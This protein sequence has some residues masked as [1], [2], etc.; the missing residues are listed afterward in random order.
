MQTYLVHGITKRCS[1]LHSKSVIRFQRLKPASEVC[2]ANNG[3]CKLCRLM[4]FMGILYTELRKKQQE[5]ARNLFDSRSS[6]G[7]SAHVV[8]RLWIS[9]SK[10]NLLLCWRSY[11]QRTITYSRMENSL[12]SLKR[13]LLEV[14]PWNFPPRHDVTV[15]RRGWSEPRSFQICCFFFYVRPNY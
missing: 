7:R 8:S 14:P 15:S 13:V 3:V 10:S 9:R 1:E 12:K 11:S 4:A 5:G 2:I 6:A